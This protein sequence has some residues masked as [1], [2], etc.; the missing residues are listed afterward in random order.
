MDSEEEFSK[1]MYFLSMVVMEGENPIRNADGQRKT[2]S[3]VVYT[4]NGDKLIEQ[5]AKSQTVVRMTQGMNSQHH[6][7]LVA[8]SNPYPLATPIP[9]S[10]GHI[11]SQQNTN[12]EFQS[13]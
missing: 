5:I 8:I 6:C 12:L 1:N 7:V 9:Q 11:P 2:P 10:Y 3:V 4:Q 13:Q